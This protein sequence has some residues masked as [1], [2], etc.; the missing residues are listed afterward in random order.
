MNETVITD[1]G[2][3]SESPLEFLTK[4]LSNLSDKI[5]TKKIFG[6][7][8]IKN[9]GPLSAVYIEINKLNLIIGDNNSGKSTINKMLS[10]F[11]DITIS[12]KKEEQVRKSFTDSEINY[13]NDESFIVFVSAINTIIISK[14][15]CFIHSALEPES[16]KKILD[17]IDKLEL[18]HGIEIALEKAKKLSIIEDDNLAFL[19]KVHEDMGNV[20]QPINQLLPIYIP[21]ER[22]LLSILSGSLFSLMNA[23]IPLSKTLIRF[24]SS[25]EI[26]RKRINSIKSPIMD[27]SYQYENGKDVISFSES[28]KLNLSESSS[29]IQATIPLFIVL[30]HL[31]RTETANILVE[32]PEM[33]L[34]P[35][36][37][38]KMANYLS[39][40]CSGSFL[41]TVVITTHSP[42]I[43]SAFNNLIVA[44][45]LAQEKPE[46]VEEIA[47]IIPQQSWIKYDDVSAYVLENGT[48]RSI[49]DPEWQAIVADEIDKA[50]EEIGQEYD[51]LLELKY[52][53][54]SADE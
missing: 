5:K 31:G 38:K 11:L 13:F 33:N 4:I 17:A 45:T 46:L 51:Q 10:V 43:L 35:K 19:K 50:S 9:F 27:I 8:L 30:E 49:L 36:M 39:T 18:H 14:T 7:L 15:D 40:F 28:G 53:G 26:A 1:K 44:G 32:E 34:F 6:G 54:H 37:Q 47:S 21:A 42:Y 41:N 16:N 22:N 29:S 12:G 20:S 23:D 24:G 3:S 2:G 48:A 52:R 25:Y